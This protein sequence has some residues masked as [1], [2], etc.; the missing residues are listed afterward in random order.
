MQEKLSIQN[1]NNFRGDIFARMKSLEEKTSTSASIEEGQTTDNWLSEDSYNRQMQRTDRRLSEIDGRVIEIHSQMPNRIKK[2]AAILMRSVFQSLDD[3]LQKTSNDPQSGPRMV[4]CPN[5]KRK[6]DVAPTHDD[7]GKTEE[8]LLQSSGV[9]IPS[10][11][12]YYPMSYRNYLHSDN[13]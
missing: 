6:S 12:G 10:A 2:H 9:Y 3:T 4:E 5:K 8:Q 11:P 1:S 13:N 7:F